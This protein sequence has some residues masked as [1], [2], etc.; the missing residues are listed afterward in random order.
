MSQGVSK[1]CHQSSQRI[2]G[3]VTMCLMTACTMYQGVSILYHMQQ[4]LQELLS[5]HC[6]FAAT[7]V[8]S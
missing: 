7:V 3:L 4:E 5:V 8:C 1:Q 6:L 2:I